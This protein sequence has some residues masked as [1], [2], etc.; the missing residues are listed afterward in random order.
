VFPEISFED[1][2]TVHGLQ[3][4]CVIDAHQPEHAKALLNKF[5]MPFEK[6]KETK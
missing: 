3:V 6:I 1:S 5:G 4:V 2:S